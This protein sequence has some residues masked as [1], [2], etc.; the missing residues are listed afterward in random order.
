M[1]SRYQFLVDT[2][3][4]EILKVLSVWASF[5]DEDMEI[6]P[7]AT[8]KRGRT[9]HEHM[10]H[11]CISEDTWFRNMFGIDVGVPPLPQAETRSTFI[12]RYAADAEKRLDE[13]RKQADVWW[14][15][16]VKFFNVLR[17]RTW[18]M[19]RRLAHTAHHRGQQM[20][21]LRM[22]NREV[23]SNY[24]PTADTGGLMVNNAA[25]VYAYSDL[26]DLLAGGD[27]TPLPG[28]G[29]K[30]VSERPEVTSGT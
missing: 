29:S 22:L 4:T 13:L 6:R 25:V 21:L 16:D 24:G 15:Q 27:P 30:P 18:I 3:Q 19:V 26:E 23:Y 7:N 28:P 11:Q 8:D 5:H 17:P 2:Y 10:V 12:G 9:I 20:A 1:S 14:E